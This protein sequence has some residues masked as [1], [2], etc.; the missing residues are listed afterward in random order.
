MTELEV[1]VV[2]VMVLADDDEDDDDDLATGLRNLVQRPS[3]SRQ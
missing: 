3:A 1:V 2:V